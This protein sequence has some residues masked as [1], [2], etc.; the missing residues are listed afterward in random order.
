[1]QSAEPAIGYDGDCKYGGG[2][3][4]NQTAI[5]FP[6]GLMG[7]T[8]DID[9]WTETKFDVTRRETS[10]KR[11]FGEVVAA[12]EAGAPVVRDS[13]DALVTSDI[14]AG[15]LR[16]QIENHLGPSGFALFMKVEHIAAFSTPSEIR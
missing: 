13:L 3:A 10:T 11:P 9:M 14:K 12:I 2:A 7:S 5:A 8:G 16:R 15:D 1:L 4:S 6:K